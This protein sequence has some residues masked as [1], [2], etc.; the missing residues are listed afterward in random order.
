MTLAGLPQPDKNST[1]C[2]ITDYIFDMAYT[3]K[4]DPLKLL[5]ETMDNI[6]IF[7]KQTERRTKIMQEEY[8]KIGNGT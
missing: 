7:A 5:E 6:A 2:P 3:L 4:C 1:N 8:D